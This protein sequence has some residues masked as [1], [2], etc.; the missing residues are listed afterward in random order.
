MPI[1]RHRVTGPGPAGDVWSTGLF[2]SGS[3][4]LGTAHDAWDDFV[5]S[6]IGSDMAGLWPTET[7]ATETITDQLDAAGHHNVAQARTSV[8]YKG[9]GTGLQLPQRAAVVIGL[10]TALPTRSGRGRM[11]VPAP[12]SSSL[13]ADGILS[14]T[15]ADAL[16]GDAATALETM[17]AIVQVVIAHRDPVTKGISGTT[18]VT[19]VTVGQ[20]L[21][22]QRRRTNKVPPN[23]Q[24]ADL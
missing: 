13:T 1:F 16:A 14:S 20:V 4:S 24:S 3:A 23:Y 19:Y 5:S 17:T 8:T 11:Y 15:V 18:P 21:G 6:F 12:D 7:Q 2:S 9:T 22:S 10:R